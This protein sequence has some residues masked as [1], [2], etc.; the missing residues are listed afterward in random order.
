NLP[1]TRE[2]LGRTA[3]TRGSLIDTLNSLLR[4]NNQINC[5]A[6]SQGSPPFRRARACLVNLFS[7]L[8]ECLLLPISENQPRLHRLVGRRTPVRRRQCVV[9]DGG[10]SKSTTDCTTAGSS[11][12]F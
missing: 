12:N 9:V 1:Q 10:K 4:V 5:Y 3:R 2:K 8:K 7:D 11:N 6:F